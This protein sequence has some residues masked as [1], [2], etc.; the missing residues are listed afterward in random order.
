MTEVAATEP[1]LNYLVET[2]CS[3][4]E[5][6]K[7]SLLTLLT[8]LVQGLST[9]GWTP[10]YQNLLEDFSKIYPYHWFLMSALFSETQGLGSH[11]PRLNMGGLRE[12]VSPW[13]HLSPFQTGMWRL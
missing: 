1:T 13:K 3:L 5:T 8:F 4:T 11:S 10:R 6:G 7:K 9:L 2:K 12:Q